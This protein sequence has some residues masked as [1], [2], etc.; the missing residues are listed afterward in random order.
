M[1]KIIVRYYRKKRVPE[2]CVV[3]VVD[4]GSYKLGWSLYHKKLEKM[5]GKTFTKKMARGIATNRVHCDRYGSTIIPQSLEYTANI[6]ITQ[7]EKYITGGNENGSRSKGK[8]NSDT[9]KD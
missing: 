5:A 8:D 2:G 1:G 4:G 3:G 7:C 9:V 6:V